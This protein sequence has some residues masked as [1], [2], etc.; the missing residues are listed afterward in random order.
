MREMPHDN[1]FELKYKPSFILQV[2]ERERE[3]KEI[4]MCFMKEMG[5]KNGSV[6]FCRPT[7]FPGASGKQGKV[8]SST[9]AFLE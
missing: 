1:T 9:Q 4:D 3:R 8:H 7:L 5:F 6:V 2:S